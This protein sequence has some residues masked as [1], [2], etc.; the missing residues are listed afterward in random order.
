MSDPAVVVVVPRSLLASETC[1]EVGEDDIVSRI[2]SVGRG[3]KA[4]EFDMNSAVELANRRG[5]A[6]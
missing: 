1:G 3:G 5:S 6:V 4:V 2:G